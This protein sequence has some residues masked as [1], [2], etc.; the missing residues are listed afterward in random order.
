MLKQFTASFGH[1]WAT[2]ADEFNIVISLLQSS[3][4]TRTVGVGAWLSGTNENAILFGFF[5]HNVSAFVN[6]I[7][8]KQ[9]PDIVG[10][11]RMP[12]T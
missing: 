11:Q 2:N 9:Q 7:L 4:Q 6:K 8:A 12:D 3:Y 10:I 1:F 5:R